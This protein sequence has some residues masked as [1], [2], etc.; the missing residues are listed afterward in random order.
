[1]KAKIKS[2]N[3][4]EDKKFIFQSHLRQAPRQGAGT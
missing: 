1:M 3:F 4:Q 2:Y